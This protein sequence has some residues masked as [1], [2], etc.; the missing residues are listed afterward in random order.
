MEFK[1]I[2]GD[3]L[4]LKSNVL[5]VAKFEEDSVSKTV[6]KVDEALKGTITRLVD[7]ENFKGELGKLLNVNTI[8]KTGSDRVLVVGLGKKTD[9]TPSDLKKVGIA[10]AKK[11]KSFASNVN[12]AMDIEASKLNCQHLITGLI[13]G[14][15]D[16]NKYKSGNN[17]NNKDTNYNFILSKLSHKDFES[18]VE[19]GEGIGDATCFTRD[20]VNEPPDTMTP[21][22]LAE[23]AKKISE[24]NGLEC[25][26][27]NTVE[28]RERKMGGLY[29]VS[30]GSLQ[31]PRFI[32]LTY[33]PKKK[34]KKT[35]AIVGKGITFDSGG[36]CIK[37]A[38]YMKTMKMDMGG[39]AVVLG[40]MKAITLLKPSVNVHA[41]I[42][43]TENMT[44]GGAYKP[45][46]VV[47]AMNGKTMEIVNTDAEGR[48]V[49]SDALSFAV[50]LG[51]DEIVDLATLTGA[52]LV[53]LGTYTAGVM[54]NDQ[55][56]INRVLKAANTVGEKI[57]QLPMDDELRKDIESDV[58]DVKNV[59]SRYGGAITAGMFLEHFVDNTPWAHIDIA[60]PTFIE[61]GGE[62]YPKGATG[63]G[64]Q[65]ILQYLME[66]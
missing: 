27:F 41:L 23:T 52:C 12:I 11:V 30:K 53:A 49:L 34:A 15:Y 4:K 64:V 20:L 45:D 25:E 8:G 7:E 10:V 22:K 26:I 16:Y 65:T 51:V 54:G 48:V 61:R 58:A 17:E 63:F 66:R 39:S 13:L 1:L 59:G 38:D 5:V 19:L 56:V 37:P 44:G 33:K 55:L 36:L 28:I 31:D 50:E 29:A 14:T 43:A 21:T 40:V 47:T 3:P 62:F 6:K 57:W 2:K 60:G 32:H 42:S 9:F 24:E 35:V 18:S 46:D